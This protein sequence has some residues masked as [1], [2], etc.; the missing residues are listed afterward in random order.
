MDRPT[1]AVVLAGGTGTRLYPASRSDRPKQL[2]AFGGDRSLLARTMDRVAFCDRRV[3]LTGRDHA[4]AVREELRTADVYGPDVEVL[5]EP[6]SR[7]TGPALVY[8]AAWVRDRVPDAVVLCVPSDHRVEG[9]FAGVARRACRTAV[10]TGGLVTLGVDPTR[11]ATGYGYVV[12]DEHKD[13]DAGA[14]TDARPVERFTEKPDRETATDL[15]ATGAYWNAGV[16]AW[17]PAAFLGAAA[18]SPLSG[19]VDAAD[20]GSAALDRAMADADEVS[21]DSAV[22]ERATDVFVVPLTADWD[23]LGSWDA[24][25]RLGAGVDPV[26]RDCDHRKDRNA[27]TTVTT[28]DAETDAGADTTVTANVS[29]DDVVVLGDGLALDCADTLVATDGEVHVS[30]VG[31]TDAVVAAYGDRVLVVPK[32]ESQRVREV[33]TRLREDSRF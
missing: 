16:F 5:V 27:D 12:P 26:G 28:A 20:R 10:T 14:H 11:P 24:V 2:L 6:H 30:A 19:L 1:V 18:D 31:L 15:V 17:T 13:V 4:E 25:A 29:E 9:D 32:S 33:V 8:A 3:V 23:D 22:L 7:D 21:V